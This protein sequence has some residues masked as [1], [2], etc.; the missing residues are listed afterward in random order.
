M[1]IVYKNK[2]IG[3]TSCNNLIGL[4]LHFSLHSTWWF[5]FGDGDAMWD[6]KVF[7]FYAFLNFGGTVE[8]YTYRG[9]WWM[10]ICW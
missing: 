10:Y 8:A 1:S 7:L 3:N 6:I 9:L 4:N 2:P 5:F